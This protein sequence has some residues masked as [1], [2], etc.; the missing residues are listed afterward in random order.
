[1]NSP[2]RKSEARFAAGQRGELITVPRAYHAPT[3]I[4]TEVV[5]NRWLREATRL[6]AEYWRTANAKH[7]SAFARHVHGMRV[8]EGRRRL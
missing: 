5:W 4:Q 8:H 7:L 1:M 6:F 2:P 3:L